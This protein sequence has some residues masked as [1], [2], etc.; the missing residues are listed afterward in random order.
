[1]HGIKAKKLKMASQLFNK[2]KTIHIH[3]ILRPE[4]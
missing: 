4:Y 3:K 2:Q 1:M